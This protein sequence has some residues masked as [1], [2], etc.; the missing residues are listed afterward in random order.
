MFKPVYNFQAPDYFLRPHPTIH[1]EDGL[2]TAILGLEFEVTARS[3][4]E[5]E[6]SL[7]LRCSSSV[8]TVNTEAQTTE[9]HHQKSSVHF[10]YGS[11]FRAGECMDGDRSIHVSHLIEGAV[12]SVARG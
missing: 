7:T 8:A 5:N 9:T 1:H 2:E 11:L 6:L 10:S 3:F 4:P 12:I